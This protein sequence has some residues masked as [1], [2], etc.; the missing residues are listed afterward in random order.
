MSRQPKGTYSSYLY[1]GLFSIKRRSSVADRQWFFPGQE[2][3]RRSLQA[4]LPGA[5]RSTSSTITNPPWGLLLRIRTQF[6]TCGGLAVA[7]FGWCRSRG[8]LAA[9]EWL[10]SDSSSVRV[11][12]AHMSRNRAE[13]LGFVDVMLEAVTCVAFVC[14]GNNVAARK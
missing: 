13:R 14:S 7:A 6:F 10:V 3:E 9:H 1:L 11:V 12:I 2:R 8:P 4:I 5:E